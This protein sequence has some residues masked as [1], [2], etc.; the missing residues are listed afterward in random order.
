MTQEQ[1]QK[2]QI[3]YKN[4]C[5][6]LHNNLKEGESYLINGNFH[7]YEGYKSTKYSEKAHIFTREGRTAPLI[8]N[9][10]SLSILD[11]FETM[12]IKKL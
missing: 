1:F 5:T 2:M 8:L 6:Y 7:K 12:K 4:K 10:E 3:E 11:I 9:R